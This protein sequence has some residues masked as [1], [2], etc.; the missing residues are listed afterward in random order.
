M[1]KTILDRVFYRLIRQWVKWIGITF[2]CRYRVLILPA[3]FHFY[4]SAP[5]PPPV[6]SNTNFP[7]TPPITTTTIIIIINIVCNR[8]V[9][10]YYIFSVEFLAL[11][12]A[13]CLLF[14]SN[15]IVTQFQLSLITDKQTNQWLWKLNKVKVSLFVWRR[16]CGLRGDEVVV[17]VVREW[18]NTENIE[19]IENGLVASLNTT[20][21]I[22][23][24]IDTN[25]S[26]SQLR[27]EVYSVLPFL[28][29]SKEWPP[30]DRARDTLPPHHWRIHS[31][32][33]LSK[34][35]RL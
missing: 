29:F 14:S 21:H 7:R 25:E 33:T 3:L 6:S 8:L 16:Q 10:L 30:I 13:Q 32:R 4:L 20:W 17:V 23:T 35:I 22:K 11:S 28:F 15:C 9:S 18:G 26:E 1:E 5:R 12:F 2:T 31:S 34:I 27:Q 19:N 24:Q